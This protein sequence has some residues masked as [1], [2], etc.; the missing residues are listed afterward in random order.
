MFTISLALLALA[1]P[2]G[3]GSSTAPVVI[4]EIMYDNW[5]NPDFREFVELYNRSGADVDIS[6]WI[7]DAEDW[8]G[9]LANNQD[10]VV[11]ANTILAA[12]DY[13][14][15][16]AEGGTVPNTDQVCVLDPGSNTGLWE[17][18]DEGLMIRDAQGTIIDAVYW[19]AHE[20]ASGGWIPHPYLIEGQGI[21][22]SPNSLN[23]HPTS[24]S[25]L[26]DGYDTNNN[27]RDFRTMPQT[28]GESNDWPSLFPYAVGTSGTVGSSVVNWGSSFDL[29]VIA[30]P[31]VASANNPVAIPLSP[32]G[33][34]KVF[35]LPPRAS[36]G[37]NSAGL[38]GGT[39]HAMLLTAPDVNVR[40]EAYIYFDATPEAVDPN[41]GISEGYAWS[42]GVQGHSDGEYGF[43]DVHPTLGTTDN[44]DCGITLTYVKDSVGA[45]L[46]LIDHNDG[47][48]DHTI[49]GQM[50]ITAGVNDGWQRVR[51]QASQNWAEA[52]FGGTYGS[53]D[54]VKLAGPI[55]GHTGGVWVSQM[56]LRYK[57]GALPVPSITQRPFTADAFVA[58]QWDDGVEFL[59]I[60]I[61]NTVGTPGIST[62]S[63]P[64]LANPVFEIHV[65]GLVPNSTFHWLFDF[66]PTGGGPIPLDVFG[67]P[68][69]AQLW[70]VPDASVPVPS[71]GA[72]TGMLAFAVDPSPLWLGAEMIVQAFQIDFGLP[73]PLPLS[74]SP[75]LRVQFVA[76]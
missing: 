75:G 32:A 47:G 29:A 2:Q 56:V 11:P 41:T 72:G 31:A 7:L 1:A 4:N 42:L 6:G 70:A 61:A 40:V 66:P 59:G 55:V 33:N 5:Q 65:D 64:Y 14:V 58:E 28:P 20:T 26:S 45:T 35:C 10:F 13:Y 17:N 25:R 74:N 27:G 52:H 49:L 39:Q 73:V 46:Y 44:G 24:W 9:A 12:G 53:D 50:A 30:D 22:G 21:W 68:T 76:F 48:V 57:G 71:D 67:A 18:G 51:L 69:G 15:F 38:G 16:G 36:D 63:F 23:L 8:Q 43:P 62:R 60:G 37:R 54:G 3:A 34:H 19:E